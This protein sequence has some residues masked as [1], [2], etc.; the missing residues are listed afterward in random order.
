MKD[1][2]LA[3]LL[4]VSP[5]RQPGSKL[6]DEIRNGESGT[7]EEGNVS[8]PPAQDEPSMMELMIAAQREA[9]ADKLSREKEN[10]KAVTTTIGSGFKKGF[11]GQGSSKKLPTTK[12]KI[13]PDVVIKKDGSL[14]ETP[15]ASAAA[16]FDAN[17]IE[18][19]KELPT[20]VKPISLKA[21][22]K[23]GANDLISADV[24]IAMTDGEPQILKQLKQGGKLYR[25]FAVKLLHLYEVS[26]CI[27]CVLMNLSCS[28]LA[29]T[30]EWVTPALLAVFQEN[31]VIKNGLGNQKCTQA[32]QLMLSDPKEAKKRFEGDSEVELFMSVFGK[33]MS[34]HFDQLGAT[35]ENQKK[36]PGSKTPQSILE[37]ERPI[38]TSTMGVLHAEAVVRE[39]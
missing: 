27:E 13:I 37:C 32:L 17:T 7:A 21:R 9:K 36:N 2:F 4:A 23:S 11:F 18:S 38:D 35:Q 16:F 20:V 30:I 24:Q 19:V 14:L 10:T 31:E 5:G 25:I 39:R 28:Y 33:V 6:V 29:A 26:A 34:S 12:A 15:M 8:K 3:S 1:D 22:G